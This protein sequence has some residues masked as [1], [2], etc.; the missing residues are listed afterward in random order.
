MVAEKREGCQRACWPIK[1]MRRLSEKM[2]ETKT[3][4]QIPKTGRSKRLGRMEKRPLAQAFSPQAI[5]PRIRAP[6]KSTSLL[7]SKNSVVA[8]TKKI[9]R[10]KARTTISQLMNFSV[11]W[12]NFSFTFS[13]LG[14]LIPLMQLFG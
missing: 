3:E 12:A 8:G 14:Y 5:N 10:R 1:E 2:V 4:S 6:D 13:R 11:I 7:N 9:G